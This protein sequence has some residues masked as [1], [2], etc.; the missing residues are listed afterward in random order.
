M[1]SWEDLRAKLDLDDNI[2]FF[3]KQIIH[4]NSHPWKEIFLECA[5]N[6]SNV[7]IN[8]HHLIKKHQ[9]YCLEKVNSGEICNMQ[10]ILM[11]LTSLLSSIFVI[12]LVNN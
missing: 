9:I 1:R 3:W 7:I 4:T 8:K 6:I 12:T 11:Q 2:I 10:L 5:N